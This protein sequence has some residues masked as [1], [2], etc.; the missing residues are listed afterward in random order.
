MHWQN[1]A[2]SLCGLP[3]L[4]SGSDLALGLPQLSLEGRDLAL[5]LAEFLLAY[6][7]VSQTHSLS[8]KERRW[9][10]LEKR[11]PRLLLSLL[12][13]RQLFLEVGDLIAQLLQLGLVHAGRRHRCRLRSGRSRRSGVSRGLKLLFE[14]R[15]VLLEGADPR[16]ELSPFT[17]RRLERFCQAAEVVKMSI[18]A[19]LDQDK[20]RPTR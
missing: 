1:I 11:R 19:G 9:T 6:R 5:D 2:H 16:L 15:L 14:L 8:R 3:G 4:D 10:H 13:V 20:R 18:G 17:A 12:R 7:E